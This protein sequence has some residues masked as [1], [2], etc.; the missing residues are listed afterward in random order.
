[1]S[2]YHMHAKRDI[3]WDEVASYLEQVLENVSQDRIVSVSHATYPSG[4]Y[5]GPFW[6][7]VI[8]IVRKSE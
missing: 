3:S 8:V 7:S 5:G 6:H 2:D 1:M 4:G